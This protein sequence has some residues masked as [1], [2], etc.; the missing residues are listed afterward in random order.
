MIKIA[1]LTAALAM[2]MVN[3][4]YAQK[5]GS[6][7]QTDN[8]N[9]PGTT[10][11]NSDA[12]QKSTTTGASASGTSSGG[13]SAMTKTGGANGTPNSMPKTTT[14]PTGDASKDESPAK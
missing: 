8:M 14:G 13:G 7:A 4:A 10:N 11:L 5:T 3:G 9:K 12:T 6:A 2:G 1:A